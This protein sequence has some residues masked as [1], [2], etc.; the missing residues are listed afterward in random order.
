MKNTDVTLE[1][2]NNLE[3]KLEQESY[4]EL[5]KAL[6]FTAAEWYV[7]DT[8]LGYQVA[9]LVYGLAKGLREAE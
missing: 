1:D 7:Q 4:E 2:L 9:Y 3:F 5:A 6:E 8:A